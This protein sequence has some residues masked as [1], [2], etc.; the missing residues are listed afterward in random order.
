[1]AKSVGEAMGHL[2]SLQLMHGDLK[3]LNVVRMGSQ[4]KLIDLDAIASFSSG[5]PSNL[6]T[7]AGAKFSSGILPP[8]MFA[9]LDKKGVLQYIAYW[10]TYWSWFASSHGPL[11]QGNEAQRMS[12]VTMDKTSLTENQYELWKKMEPRRRGDKYYVVKTF[13][14]DKEGKAIHAFEING[15]GIISIVAGQGIEATK[16]SERRQTLGQANRSEKVALP[17]ALVPA[18]AAID[19][20]AFGALLF[21]LISATPLISVSRDEDAADEVAYESVFEWG[22]NSKPLERLIEIKIKRVDPYAAKLLSCLL[23]P[24]PSLR[25]SIAGCINDTFFKEQ[26]LGNVMMALDEL[27]DITRRIDTKL[28]KVLVKLD[29]ISEQIEDV[30]ECQRRGFEAILQQAERFHKEDKDY[31]K[32][33]DAKLNAQF[34]LLKTIDGKIDGLSEQLAKGFLN[35]EATFDRMSATI[36]AELLVSGEK[37]TKMMTEFDAFHDTLSNMDAVSFDKESIK[38]M[39]EDSMSTL[40]KE[41]KQ[42]L[43]ESMVQ[44]MDKASG[45]DIDPS[46][47]DK[48][49]HLIEMVTSTKEQITG[50]KKDVQ[51]LNALSMSLTQIPTGSTEKYIMPR[52]FILVPVDNEPE[53]VFTQATTRAHST[54]IALVPGEKK[55]S[56]FGLP[57]VGISKTITT[58]GTIAAGAVGRSVVGRL[59]EKG[60]E[61]LNK[62]CRGAYRLCWKRLRVQ[63]ICP[64]TMQP[65]PMVGPEGCIITLPT[66]FLIYSAKALKYGMIILKIAM[67]TQGLG[68]VVPDLSGIIPVNL[69]MDI[70]QFAS[71]YTELH[72][73]ATA[74][75]DQLKPN[76]STPEGQVLA[77]AEGAGKDKTLAEIASLR[78]KFKEQFKGIADG[79][80]TT[81]ILAIY[82]LIAEGRKQ[83]LESA[84]QSSWQPKDVQGKAW[85]MELTK[86]RDGKPG[87]MIWA[88]EEGAKRLSEEGITALNPKA[89]VNRDTIKTGSTATELAMSA[90]A[91]AADALAK[92]AGI[93]LVA[94][95][96]RCAEKYGISP[97]A[98]MSVVTSP[99]FTQIVFDV[100][101]EQKDKA[102]RSSEGLVLDEMQISSGLSREQLSALRDLLLSGGNDW[103]S[104]ED[105]AAAA[106]DKSGVFGAK[107][108]WAMAKQAKSLKITAIERR[109]ETTCGLRPGDVEAIFVAAVDSPVFKSSV[110]KLI[111]GD[112]GAATDLTG[113]VLDEVVGTVADRTGLPP[114]TINAVINAILTGNLTML[115][116]VVKNAGKVIVAGHGPKAVW[117]LA[118]QAKSLKIAAIER[119]AEE[120]GLKPGEVETLFLA[121][122]SDPVFVAAMQ[123]LMN[124]QP[125]AMN[126]ILEGSA[127]DALVA[128]VADKTGLLHAKVKAVV[129]ALLTMDLTALEA[130]ASVSVKPLVSPRGTGRVVGLRDEVTSGGASVLH[131]VLKEKEVL[132]QQKEESMQ[133]ALQQNE[134]LLLQKDAAMQQKDEILKQNERL[135]QQKDEV[136]K[137]KDETMQLLRSQLEEAKQREADL[138]RSTTAG[139]IGPR[140]STGTGSN[141]FGFRK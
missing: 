120:H 17:Y 34:E 78:D 39:M 121:A 127:W 111:G 1:M 101:S 66:D 16:G 18:S 103:T 67:A 114:D 94:I 15:S 113:D 115:E 23:E 106:L 9:C 99:I 125:G 68:G 129:T 140:D 123:A 38:M 26:S 95:K 124:H 137:Q 20:W 128:V 42:Q 89:D 36:A 112:H 32:A 136:L 2:H 8:E 21:Y 87:Q 48:L 116:E 33:Q 57:D 93:N 134:R 74:I 28:D 102:A 135:L 80:G 97:D 132:L 79:D 77:A 83:T 69:G 88:S 92:T 82:K 118:K 60:K 49:D 62:A 119:R 105:L 141:F 61:A 30:L 110:S 98:V 139:A 19:A 56:R 86:P 64:V 52:T 100:A 5:S 12:S 40:S 76:T 35:V 41:M 65:V 22:S 6:L 71:E 117:A 43:E 122:A 131:E 25:L 91:M 63:F 11:E 13:A 7:F 47:K 109:A 126:V 51:D 54:P 45:S 130:L 73:E 81:E 72:G 50:M 104:L 108:L 75:L 44:V 55:K 46:K 85:G 14:T 4:L 3:M 70:K 133:A 27:T 58:A 31:F 53:P 107:A 29:R 24:N 37:Q 10:K 138:L 84:L 59:M 90:A 96:Q